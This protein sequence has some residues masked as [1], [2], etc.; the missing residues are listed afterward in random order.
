MQ[1]RFV[2]PGTGGIYRFAMLPVCGPTTT[3]G[4][5]QN[6]LSVVNF[7]RRRSI[8]GQI[9]RRRLIEGEKGKKKKKKRKRRKKK[10]EEEGKKKE[11]PRAVLVRPSLPF[12]GRPRVACGPSLPSPAIFLPLEEKDQGD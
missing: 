4:Y 9:D 7:G 5:C 1:F 8:E 3:R 11:V 12:A 2:L 10:E 6:R